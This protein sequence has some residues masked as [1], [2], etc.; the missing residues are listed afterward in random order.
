MSK[1][2]KMSVA[3]TPRLAQSVRDAVE[4][5]DYA[6]T[7]E[8]VRAALREWSDRRDGPTDSQLAEAWRVGLASGPARPRESREEFLKRNLPRL[9]P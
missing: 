2:E 1:V 9:E 8:V 7:S 4:S 5:G 6:T 3:L